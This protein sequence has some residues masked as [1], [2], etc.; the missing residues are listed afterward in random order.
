MSKMFATSF[1]IRLD[2]GTKLSGNKYPIVLQIIYDRKKRR[3][4]LGMTATLAQ[5]DTKQNEFRKGVHRRR[6]KNEKL[7]EYLQKQKAFM[8]SILKVEHSITKDLLTYLQTTRL[9]KKG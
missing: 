6:E 3:K 5:W 4:R 9:N 2:K 1:A 8:K 7:E